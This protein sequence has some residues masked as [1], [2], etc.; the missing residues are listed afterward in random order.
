MKNVK[1]KTANNLVRDTAGVH[2]VC[3][4]CEYGHIPWNVC[5]GQR[6]TI[7]VGSLY[8]GFLDPT[9]AVRFTVVTILPAESS[10]QPNFV[11]YCCGGGS[12]ILVLLK[13][14]GKSPWRAKTWYYITHA[15]SNSLC[16]IV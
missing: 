3:T 12:L 8:H 5:G 16:N 7:E 2:R 13:W 11:V 14:M 6:T 1:Y 9:Q 10:P 15:A 4:M